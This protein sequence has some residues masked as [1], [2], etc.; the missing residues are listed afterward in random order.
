MEFGRMGLGGYGYRGSVSRSI[1]IVGAGAIALLILGVLVSVVGNATTALFVVGLAA[2]G[3]GS[4][5]L[6]SLF[7]YEVG[8]SEE[9][10]REDHPSG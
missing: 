4:V 5:V 3:L 9:R 10:D 1:L 8:R 6:V 2:V 7:F